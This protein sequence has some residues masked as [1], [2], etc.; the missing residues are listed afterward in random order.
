MIYLDHASTTPVAPE[1][2]LAMAPYFSDDFG[3]P[4]GLYSLSRRARKAIEDS[5]ANIAN[6]LNCQKDEVYFTSGGTESD[7]LAVFGLARALGN[8][9]IITT[10]I[11]HHGIMHPC[12]RLEKEGFDVTYLSVD[13][14]GL[15]NLKELKNSLRADTFLVSI[16]YANNEIG[17]IEPI[18]EVSKII[19]DYKKSSGRTDIYLHSDACQATNYLDMD[20]CALGVDLLT[21]S[22]SKIYAPKGIGALFVKSGIKLEPII[23]GGGQENS[24]RSGTENVAFI[25]GL[26]RAIDLVREKKSQTAEIAKTRDL[27]MEKL[28]EIEASQLNGSKVDRL[29]NNINIS[30]DGIEGESA[31]LHLDR[32]GIAVSTGSAC[33]SMSLEPSHVIVAL[34]KPKEVAHSSLRF[35][36]GRNFDINDLDVVIKSV[37][38]V[39]EKLRQ[40]SPLWKK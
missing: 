2:T 29:A 4:S 36:L 16:M 30:F 34:G 14:D 20:V 8:G 7:N 32:L 19:D 5:R 11:E 24:L 38:E 33:T 17:T 28:L 18:A 15:I 39:V 35:T 21:F 27:M 26:S 10:Q 6:F 9:H 31:V 3:N 25:V 23:Y 13:K 37:R 1:V 22:G 12:Q 40:M